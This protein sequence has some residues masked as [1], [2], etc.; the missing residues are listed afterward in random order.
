MYKYAHTYT[1]I[2]IYTRRPQRLLPAAAASLPA[3]SARDGFHMRS[4]RAAAVM[5]AAAVIPQDADEQNFISILSSPPPSL[6]SHSVFSSKRWRSNYIRIRY[7]YIRILVYIVCPYHY[8][9]RII[10]EASRDL[11][12]IFLKTTSRFFLVILGAS[13]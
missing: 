13:R 3:S 1:Q 10:L 6:H 9:Y 5:A 11:S 12:Y 8:L 4:L 2:Y 7:T